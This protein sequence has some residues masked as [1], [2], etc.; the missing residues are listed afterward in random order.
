M[1]QETLRQ[2]QL[3]QLE[4]LKEVK[5]VCDQ[6]Q[7]HYWLDSGTFLGAVRHGGFIPWDDDLDIGMLRE[8]YERFLRIC[9]DTLSEQYVLQDWN[10]TPGYPYAFAKVR[11]KGTVY[12][13]LKDESFSENGIFIDIFPYDKYPLDVSKQKRQRIMVDAFKRAVLVKQGYKAWKA[14]GKTNW[15]R[16]VAF[17][18]MRVLAILPL[19]RLKCIYLKNQKKYNTLQEGYA[20]FPS[21]VSQYGRWVIA[22]EY[23]E[24]LDEIFFED[25]L[26][27][28]PSQA[29][30]YLTSAYGDYH[31]LPPV[32]QRSVGHSIIEVKF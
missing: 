21:G 31:K 20:Y 24:N 5:R 14:S 23:L 32:E 11:K 6:A 26:F 9:K 19:E 22:K 18:P 7:I 10:Q 16:W 17:L 1:D 28:C 13:E 2:V 3:V 4:I 15:R 12:R 29:D 8:D 30:Q 25:A 27:P